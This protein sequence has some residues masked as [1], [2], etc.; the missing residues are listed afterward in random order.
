MIKTNQLQQELYEAVLDIHA[1]VDTRVAELSELHRDKLQCR[2]GCNECCIDDVSVFEVEA[3]RIRREFPTLLADGRAADVGRCAL[4]GDDGECRVY[5]A[6]PY[7]C[8]T[9][10]LPLFWYEEDEHGEIVEERDVCH[11]NGDALHLRV[12]KEQE[13]WQ[14]GPTEQ[15][16]IDLQAKVPGAE[17]RRIRLRDLFSR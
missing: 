5:K 3:E 6:R 14:L 7:V 1:E 17:N 10:G 9:Q 15:R 8:R 12:L 2:L 13:L 4:L 16:L 11:K